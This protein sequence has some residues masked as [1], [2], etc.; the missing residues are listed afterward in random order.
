MNSTLTAL[1]A[2]IY[3]N[4][5][6]RTVRLVFADALDETGN[7]AD[8]DRAAFIRA[9]VE[10]EALPSRDP[11]WLEATALCRDLFTQHWIDWWQPV[12]AAVGLPKP[13]VPDRGI[14]GRLKRLFTRDAREPGWPYLAHPHAAS[15]E[16]H[17]LAF[18]AQ[19]I[20]GFPELL[21]IHE[22]TTGTH[23]SHFQAFFTHSAFHRLRLGRSPSDSEWD[24]LDGPHLIRLTELTVDQL[25]RDFAARLLL[26][27]L[28]DLVTLRVG[29]L[30]RDI[31]VIRPLIHNPPWA[32][33]RSLTLLGI[34]PPAAI[35]SLAT[36]CTLTGLNE[37]TF[38]IGEVSTWLPIPGVAGALGAILGALHSP[39]TNLFG[40]P[41]RIATADFWPA[42]LALAASRPF[43]LLRRLR[44]IDANVDLIERATGTLLASETLEPPPDTIFPESVVTALA[45]GLNADKLERLELPASRLS[46]A[47][48]A[49]LAERFGQRFSVA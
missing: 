36:D 47:S 48:R 32:E 21:A 22:F 16:S 15:V 26:S 4:P 24:S 33:L 2:A 37:L 14:G 7:P 44:I 5:A 20:A 34:S 13:H 27:P 30:F 49:A 43:R 6:D 3:A 41:L 45:D 39:L 28:S 23:T 17:D 1:E 40:P 10:R 46:R 8:A 35:Q 29:P 38:E 19:F 31:G 12:C 25:T 18:T 11:R 9:Q 42:L